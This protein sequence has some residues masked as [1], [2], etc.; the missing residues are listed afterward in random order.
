MVHAIC[1]CGL[2]LILSWSEPPR[3]RGETLVQLEAQKKAEPRLPIPV[4]TEDQKKEL[5]VLAKVNNGLM[6][7]YYLPSDWTSADFRRPR[8]TAG[9]NPF[10][11]AFT[12]QLFWIVSRANDCRYCLGH[13]EAKL[14]AAGESPERIA[15]LDSNW[16]A[17]SPEVQ[18]AL[19]A[20]LELTRAP[21]HYGPEE[22]RA[23]S[24]GRTPEETLE[25]VAN[26]AGFNMI[27][28]WTGALNLRQDE[29]LMGHAVAFAAP[30][31]PAD[32]DRVSVIAE[33][34]PADRGPLESREQVTAR[35]QAC[36]ART[37]TLPLADD[38]T[39]EQP[40][41]VRL[42][43]KT[44]ANGEGRIRAFT[45]YFTESALPLR[46]KA[47]IFWVAA[48]HDRAWYAL[49][50]ARGRL[51]QAGFDD[52][53]IFA[54]DDLTIDR[55][56]PERVVLAFAKKNTVQPDAITDEDIASLRA[57]FNDKQVAEIVYLTGAAAFFNR[58]TEA[59]QLPLDRH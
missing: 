13:Q 22:Q 7:T 15:F 4:L 19:R 11:P 41:W 14:L 45:A 34:L 58:L 30:P 38:P 24:T 42:F 33:S 29:E 17:F 18:S 50:V 56:A 12:T 32:R 49:D 3:T 27:N 8:P 25:I 53:A 10:G 59:A 47:M 31:S 6:R 55:S 9:G 40:G 23:L 21:Q 35:W 36:R 16:G 51:A 44:G 20:A 57:H 2:G 46:E 39:G 26:I 52:A 37:A 54:L 5:G 48:R 43:A 1:F 28:R